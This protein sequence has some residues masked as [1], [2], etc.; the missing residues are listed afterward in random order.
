VTVSGPGR[1]RTRGA[2]SH[3]SAD[4][5]SEA[6]HLLVLP[7]RDVAEEVADALADE[8]LAEV[9]VVREALAGED[10]SEDHEWAVFVRTPADPAYVRRLTALAH[11][12]DGWYDADPSS[13]GPVGG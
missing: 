7:D 8:G 4:G 9:R 13:R 5:S 12:L 10:D 11:D 1:P 2:A 6:E 3:P